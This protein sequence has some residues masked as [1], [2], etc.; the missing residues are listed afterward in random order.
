MAHVCMTCQQLLLGKN[1]SSVYHCR[2]V[3]SSVGYNSMAGI[4]TS[5]MSSDQT[6]SVSQLQLVCISLLFLK[7]LGEEG[8][9]FSTMLNGYNNIYMRGETFTN[10]LPLQQ[11]VFEQKPQHARSCLSRCLTTVPVPRELS[12]QPCKKKLKNRPRKSPCVGHWE[13]LDLGKANPFSWIFSQ[14]TS[15][16]SLAKDDQSL[17]SSKKLFCGNMKEPHSA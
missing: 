15:L 9:G 17:N 4:P 12:A 16:L 11:H 5:E 1:I 13:R 6:F 7:V 10:L 14:S 2:F 8:V 3:G